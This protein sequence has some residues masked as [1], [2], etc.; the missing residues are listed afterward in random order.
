MLIR[1]SAGFPPG[2]F[3]FK[4][5]SVKWLSSYMRALFY[6]LDN[7]EFGDERFEI[8]HFNSSL[9]FNF[10]ILYL[11]DFKRFY[12]WVNRELKC[13]RNYVNVLQLMKFIVIIE[14]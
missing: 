2:D 9:L 8:M 7:S 4:D 1:I 14:K 11:I 12:I 10:N 13:T 6:N 3:I 5:S